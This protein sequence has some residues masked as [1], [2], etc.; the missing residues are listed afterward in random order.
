VS[1]FVF[2][3]LI[4]W[5]SRSS[6]WFTNESLRF[7]RNLLA[8]I[9]IEANR[10]FVQ[11]NGDCRPN[12]DDKG[13]Q[14]QG[15]RVGETRGEQTAP[16][17]GFGWGRGGPRQLAV[18]GIEPVAGAGG[19]G[20]TPVRRRM[21]EPV[22]HLWCEAEKVVGGLVWAM[23][24]WSGASTRGWRLAGAGLGQRAQGPRMGLL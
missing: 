5:F 3:K 20:D 23:W 24:G 18:G 13:C 16:V 9:G 12:S 19:G 14:W 17:C 21:R 11:G 7:Y 1:Y 6:F 22:M 4:D 2:S 15:A 10:S 8:I